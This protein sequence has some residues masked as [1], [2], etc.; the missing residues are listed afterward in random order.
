MSKSNGAA[1]P[2]PS[3]LDPRDAQVRKEDDARV[4]RVLSSLRESGFELASVR[5]VPSEDLHRFVENRNPEYESCL[6]CGRPRESD[7][8]R[9][10]AA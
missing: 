9:M 10:V 1:A 8:H 7:H 2:V 5:E 4:A 3:S 6:R